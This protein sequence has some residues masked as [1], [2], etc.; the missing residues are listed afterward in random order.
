[1][2]GSNRISINDAD[3]HQDSLMDSVTQA[4]RVSNDMVFAGHLSRNYIAAQGDPHNERK[5]L[6][7]EAPEVKAPLKYQPK[8]WFIIF[9]ITILSLQS[10]H[11]GYGMGTWNRIGPILRLKYG[12]TPGERKFYESFVTSFL[13]AGIVFGRFFGAWFVQKG[14]KQCL[15]T[16]CFVGLIAIGIMM[17]QNI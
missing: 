4:D 10:L 2:K 17:V 3:E 1:M 8:W 6:N 9:L 11:S 16:A 13:I 15:L 14:R 12:W 7:K 5:Y